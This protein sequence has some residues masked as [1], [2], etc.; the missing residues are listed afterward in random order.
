MVHFSQRNS[1]KTS[2]SRPPTRRNE[3]S[4]GN[5]SNRRKQGGNPREMHQKYLLMAKEACTAGNHVEAELFYQ[6]AEHYYRIVSER[7]A[8]SAAR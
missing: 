4:H 6:H 3:Q 1:S 2:Q 8:P 5:N 7:M